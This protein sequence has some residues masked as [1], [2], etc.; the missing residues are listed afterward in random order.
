M[1]GAV[2]DNLHH[3]GGLRFRGWWDQDGIDDVDDAVVC[4][5]VC[6]G[7]LC[8]VDEDAFVVDGDGDFG[9][10]KCGDGLSVREVRAESRASN[11]VVEQDVG[12]FRQGKEVFGGCFECSSES[13]EGVVGGCEDR[14]WSFSA[15]CSCEVCLNDG[16]FEEVV[17]GAVDDDVHHRVARLLVSEDRDG[18]RV[19]GGGRVVVVGSWNFEVDCANAR[20]EEP[21]AVSRWEGEVLRVVEGLTGVNVGDAVHAV[22]AI[23]GDEFHAFTGVD[24]QVAGGKSRVGCVHG[25]V[26]VA[27][28]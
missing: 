2:D 22:G 24:C 15:E 4:D 11:D 5:N 17:H 7:H 18:S 3:G 23:E 16:R 28:L 20:A 21:K 27:S 6:D 13:E 19:S 25:V 14:E 12:Q 26:A 8:I 10:V 9:A 1:H